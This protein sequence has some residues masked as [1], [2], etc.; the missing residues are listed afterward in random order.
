VTPTRRALGWA[1]HVAGVAA[2]VWPLLLGSDPSGERMAHA[3]EAPIL[4]AI[5]ALLLVGSLLAERRSASEIALLGILTGVNAVLRL[6]GS[7]GGASP[8]FVLPILCG[9]VFDARFAFTLGATS[10]AAS[11]LVTGGIG[12]WL[13]FQMW[14][15]GWV[16]AGG[17]L[18]P[19]RWGRIGLAAYGWV[20]GFGFGALMNLWFWPF[21]GGVSELSY[22]PGGS[23]VE[24]LAAYWRFYVVTSFAWDAMRAL[25]NAILLAVLAHPLATVLAEARG[26]LGGRWVASSA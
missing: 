8:M 9:R 25:G 10:M 18:V 6:P 1:I 4:V 12:P 24:N 7:F 14:A 19:E 5:L 26:R 16:G 3:R 2:F 17:A 23:L 13:P 11:A 22:I 15:L 20:A 21:Q